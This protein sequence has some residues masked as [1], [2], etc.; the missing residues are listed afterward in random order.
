MLSL[1]LD[2]VNPNQQTIS[3]FR[4]SPQDQVV[5]EEAFTDH[6]GCSSPRAA[7]VQFWIMPN[8]T[9]QCEV[10]ATAI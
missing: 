1:R 7:G 10:I 6:R 3:Y 5:Q 8:N 9:R 2:E 4:D